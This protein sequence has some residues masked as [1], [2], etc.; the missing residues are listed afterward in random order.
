MSAR[1]P[2]GRAA[3]RATGVVAVRHGRPDYNRRIQDAEGR[4][5]ADEPVFLIRGQDKVA[6][7]AVRAWADLHERAG[8]DP[9]VARQARE[10]ARQM[11]LWPKK[12][13]ADL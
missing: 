11:D 13:S 8:G 6:G 1:R 12:K 10:W 7:D 4:I 3:A 2:D 9:E 5:P